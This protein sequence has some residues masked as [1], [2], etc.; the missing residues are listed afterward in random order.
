MPM[1][2]TYYSTDAQKK[3]LLASA[4]DLKQFIAD[5]LTCGDIQLKPD[6][7]SIRL[8]QT[9]PTGLLAEVELEVFAHAFAERVKKQDEICLAI[10]AYII[11]SLPQLNDVRVWLVLS[12][13]GHSWK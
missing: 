11:D 4:D 5:R 13:L 12:E 6:E 8:V 2:N 10:R 3:I 7:V 9:D 1:V